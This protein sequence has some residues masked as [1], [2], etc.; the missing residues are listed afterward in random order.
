MR[1]DEGASEGDGERSKGVK[2]ARNRAMEKQAKR[3]CREEAP[4]W[5]R[6]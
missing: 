3:R 5:M 2:Q 1:V 4:G 6:P